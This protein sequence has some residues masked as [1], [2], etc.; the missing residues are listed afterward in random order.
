MKPKGEDTC[1]LS[2]RQ[3]VFWFGGTFHIVL[4]SHA[5]RVCQDVAP[6]FVPISRDLRVVMTTTF[7][8]VT[9]LLTA[10]VMYRTALDYLGQIVQDYFREKRTDSNRV[11]DQNKAMADLQ[12]SLQ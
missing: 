4:P 8:T 12:Q 2:Q 3:S 7:G 1:T 6:F 9:L 5:L 10:F 11:P